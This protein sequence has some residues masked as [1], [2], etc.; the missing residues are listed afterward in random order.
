V[1]YGGYFHPLVDTSR[2][3]WFMTIY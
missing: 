2:L 1:A 3:Q